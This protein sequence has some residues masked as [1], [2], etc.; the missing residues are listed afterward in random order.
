M[1]DPTSSNLA[2]NL[3]R[4]R[5]RRELTQRDLASLAGVPR[6]T[7]AHLERGAGNPTLSVL[8]KLAQALGTTIEELIGGRRATAR[9]HPGPSQ[10]RVGRGRARVRQLLPDAPPGFGIERV[11]LPKGGRT[12]LPVHAA[13]GRHVVV[14]EAGDLE[15]EL[16]GE[17]YRLK[18]GDVLVSHGD[19]SPSLVNRG[20]ARAVAYSL[21]APGPSGR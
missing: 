3:K 19:V 18:S 1:L 11:E 4:L 21:V 16:G 12:E 15:L 14:C 13:G 17:P 6:P 10:P 20:A 8:V 5:E 2:E 9:V 7:L